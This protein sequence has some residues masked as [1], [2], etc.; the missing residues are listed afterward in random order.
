MNDTVVEMKNWMNKSMWLGASV[1]VRDASKWWDK[2]LIT[3]NT[4]MICLSSEVKL[5]VSEKKF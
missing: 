5:S 4:D 3:C 1:L 2:F